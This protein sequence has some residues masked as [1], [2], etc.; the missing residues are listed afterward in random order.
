LENATL[1][2]KFDFIS[3]TNSPNFWKLHFHRKNTLV[4]CKLIARLWLSSVVTS[5]LLVVSSLGRCLHI[6]ASN[7]RLETLAGSKCGSGFKLNQ[8]F[9]PLRSHTMPAWSI[10]FN[11]CKFQPEKKGK[12]EGYCISQ[13]ESSS[14][15]IAWRTFE[16]YVNLLHALLQYCQW[17][18]TK[19]KSQITSSSSVIWSCS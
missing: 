16:N 8:V 1:L 3:F 13:R 7:L 4:P 5:L 10:V 6:L 11:A 19:I 9:Q 15:F 12:Q 18:V 2:T 14:I 17:W